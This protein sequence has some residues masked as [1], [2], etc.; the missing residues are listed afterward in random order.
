MVCKNYL[1]F[2]EIQLIHRLEIDWNN[3][4]KINWQIILKEKLSKVCDFFYVESISK[5]NSISAEENEFV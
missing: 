3:R 2:W 4:H 5:D 1:S